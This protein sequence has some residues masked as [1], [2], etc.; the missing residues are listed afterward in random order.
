MTADFD[1]NPNMLDDFDLN[2]NMLDK[3]FGNV[4]RFGFATISC[5][6]HIPFDHYGRTEIALLLFTAKYA[7][8][9]DF[10]IMMISLMIF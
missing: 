1:W 7:D 6:H 4:E 2:P 8:A 9:F 10:L 5:I 3:H